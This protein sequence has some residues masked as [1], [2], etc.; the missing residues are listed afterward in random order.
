MEFLE[1]INDGVIVNGTTY[2]MTDNDTLYNNLYNVVDIESIN[3]LNIKKEWIGK[4]IKCD[5]DFSF[6]YL[7]L[8]DHLIDFNEYISIYDGDETISDYDLTL[9]IDAFDLSCIRA[10]MICQ[11]GDVNVFDRMFAYIT[12]GGLTN[13]IRIVEGGYVLI[14]TIVIT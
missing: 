6:N 8:I 10:N 11:Y 13:Q 14:G 9:A 1:Y 7:A 2:T 5:Y 3:R 12:I 4:V